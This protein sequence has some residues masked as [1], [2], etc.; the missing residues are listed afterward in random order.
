MY[1]ADAPRGEMMLIGGE[2]SDWLRIFDQYWDKLYR[3]DVYAARMRTAGVAIWC[4]SVA[5]VVAGMV[6]AARAARLAEQEQ[7]APTPTA[8]PSQE[9]VPVT[10][11][12][13]WR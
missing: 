10:D 4:V 1:M 7:G 2:E 9:L 5:L 8:T 11:E 3:A 12:Q 13:M 6:L